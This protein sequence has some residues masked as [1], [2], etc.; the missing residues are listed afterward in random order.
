MGGITQNVFAFENTSGTAYVNNPEYFPMIRGKTY[1]FNQNDP[2]NDGH[3]LIFTK[4]RSYWV[5]FTAK[6]GARNRSVILKC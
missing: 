2:S 1:T 3:P 5:Q 4:G 6:I